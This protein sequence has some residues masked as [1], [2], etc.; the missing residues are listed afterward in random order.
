M[1]FE[2]LLYIWIII[3]AM[4]Q[5]QNIRVKEHHRRN[6]SH[7]PKKYYEDMISSDV[8]FWGEDID[9]RAEKLPP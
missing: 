8:F 5:M 6:N 2:K 1:K 7:P 3:T 4:I 9:F